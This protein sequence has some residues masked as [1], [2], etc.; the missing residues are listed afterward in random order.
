MSDINSPDNGVI[1]RPAEPLSFL[2]STDIGESFLWEIRNR[3]KFILEIGG[4]RVKLLKR[5][6]ND[7]NNAHCSVC[8]DEVRKQ[9]RTTSCLACYGTGIEGGYYAEVQIIVSFVDPAV[10]KIEMFEHGV[11]TTVQPRSWTI[12]EPELRN[13]DILVKKTG[14]RLCINNVT[15][16]LFRGLRLQQKMDLEL[17]EASNIIYKIP[18]GEFN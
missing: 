12:W 1:N 9:S 16:S 3:E 4:E 6:W 5:K 15:P 8:W 17:I 7:T 18:V 11:R 10:G 13:K 2:P 14:E